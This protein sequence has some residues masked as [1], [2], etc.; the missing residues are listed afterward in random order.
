MTGIRSSVGWNAVSLGGTQGV[1]VITSLILAGMIGRE[2]FG[3]AGL[4]AV[5]VGF[6]VV[7][8]GVGLDLVL[9]QRK[10]LRDE[11]IGA[12]TRLAAFTGVT[13]WLITMLVA[14][15]LGD[16]FRTPELVNVLY[17]VSIAV[18]V[19][20]AVV[21]PM[22][23][24]MR[25]QDFASIAKAEVSGTVI[26][27][28]VGL[29]SATIEP[30]Y[31]AVVQQLVVSECCI[32]AGLV[33]RERGYVWRTTR[34][35]MREVWAFGAKLLWA[36][37]ASFAAGNSDNMIIGRQL[38]PAALG[39]YSLAY[40]AV[41]FPQQIIG[42]VAARTVIP[43]FSRLQDDPPAIADLYYRVSRVICIVV[44]APLTIVAL[45]ADPLVTGVLGDEWA[46]AVP[47]LQWL[48]AASILRLTFGNG[49]NVLVAMGRA[50]VFL[51]WRWATTVL[52]I[53][54]FVIG[55]QWGTAGVAASGV[56]LGL[57]VAYVG[58]RIVGTGIPVT[59]AGMLARLA[60]PIT[61]AAS[62]LAVWGMLAWVG[63]DLWLVQAAAATA[64]YL[65]I[66][67][68]SA[69]VRREITDFVAGSS[70]T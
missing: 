69:D 37:V 12:A 4:A 32:M 46:S 16:V 31:W 20:S 36:N 18:L 55:A 7:F 44:I 19:R 54:G 13:I 56:V 42:Q 29:I 27:A 24:L 66:I 62:I 5:Y 14:P 47:P 51:V 43:I 38:G 11:H 59:P 33:L 10:D 28:T 52:A 35:A 1:R 6:A 30:S 17:F 65:A 39:E 53:V 58:I 25:R 49:G 23:L 9:V 57:P 3:I 50:N 67:G 68:T 70:R 60:L 63:V 45:A 8:V 40:R 2:N 41:S 15:T 64:V 22:G 34:N 26:G 48:C 21:V 61:G